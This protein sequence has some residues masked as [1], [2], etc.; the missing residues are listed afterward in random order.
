MENLQDINTVQDLLK[1]Q[2]KPEKTRA[3][4]ILDE[5]YKEKPAVAAEVAYDV[6]QALIEFHS[7]MIETMVE[8]GDVD[9]AQLAGWTVDETK[10]I[11]ARDIVK[12]V[13]L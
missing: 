11:T 6:L 9:P 5:I 12:T 13:E 7:V 2:E 4:E 1:I 10:L 8:K 3:Q